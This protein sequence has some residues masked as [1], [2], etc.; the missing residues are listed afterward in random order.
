[1]QSSPQTPDFFDAAAYFENAVEPCLRGAV[2]R[3]ERVYGKKKAREQVARAV[4]VVLERI[5][6]ERLAG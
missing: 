3:V 6:V 1:M 5:K 2:G 4:L